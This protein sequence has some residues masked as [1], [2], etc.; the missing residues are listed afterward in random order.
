M[1]YMKKSSR[2][3]MWGCIGIIAVNL[4]CFLLR[5]SINQT[6]LLS[7]VIG[8]PAACLL[9]HPLTCLLDKTSAPRNP[10]KG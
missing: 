7:V 3:W 2:Y 1:F 6:L 8:T 4:I 5:E 9:L 10:K